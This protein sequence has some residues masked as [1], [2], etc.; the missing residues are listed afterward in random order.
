[1]FNSRFNIIDS[2]RFVRAGSETKSPSPSLRITRRTRASSVD[3]ETMSDQN[4]STPNVSTKIRK[5]ASVLPSQSP[6]KEEIEEKQQK[7]DIKV[8]TLA[9]VEEFTSSG[10]SLNL[11]HLSLVIYRVY[12]YTS[13]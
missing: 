12:V 11:S 5:R 13:D 10:N 9:E 8:V 4:K 6:V 3:P 7:S 2:K 1:M